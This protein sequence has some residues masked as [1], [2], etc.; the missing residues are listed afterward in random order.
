M[1]ARQREHCADNSLANASIVLTWLLANARAPLQL[2]W[3]RL[4]SLTRGRY[5]LCPA[6]ALNFLKRMNGEEDSTRMKWVA[7]LLA[8]GAR[9]VRIQANQFMW[10]TVAEMLESRSKYVD[11]TDARRI[12]WF[13]VEIHKTA[14]H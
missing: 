3:P 6:R 2:Q 4:L 5:I 1:L 9:K 13:T 10:D 14:L 11:L 8:K 12:E 7:L